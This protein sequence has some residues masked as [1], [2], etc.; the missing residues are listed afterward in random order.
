MKN[1]FR[2]RKSID[3]KLYFGIAASAFV[4]LILAWH[5][6]ST[7]GLLPQV[8]LPTPLSVLKTI[9][10]GFVTGDIWDDLYISCYR[11]FMGFLYAT[12]VGVVIGILAGSF[13]AI[14]AFIQ[15]LIEFLRYLPVPAFVPLIMV[16]VGIGEEAKIAVIFIGTLFQLIPMVVDNLK[17]VPEDYINAA[18]TLGAK[19]MTALWR[20]IIP[21]MLP[22]LMDTLRMMMGWAWTYLVVAELVAANSGLGYSILKAQRYLKTPSIF[23]GILIIGLLGLIIDRTFGLISKRIF[24]WTEGGGK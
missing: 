8:F 10:D 14:E 6:V 21:A 7:S 23:A 1:L 19:R 20:V 18:Y 9:I 22:R 12:I 2:I 11:I 13:S 15:P 16:W 4:I 17:S 5:F 24:R 3:K